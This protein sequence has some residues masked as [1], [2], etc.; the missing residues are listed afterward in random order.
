MSVFVDDYRADFRGMKMSHMGADTLKEL[1]EM[2]DRIGLKRKWFR[3][4]GI[5][6][7]Y[8]VSES[9]RELAIQNG[10]IELN[11]ADFVRRLR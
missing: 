2:A 1:H 5:I 4:K 11:P 8:D 10:A 6:P 9:K 3:E 7:H